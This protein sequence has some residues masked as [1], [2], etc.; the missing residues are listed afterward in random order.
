M[1]HA[2]NTLLHNH[3]E[4]TLATGREVQEFGGD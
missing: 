4:E 3:E 2:K 1:P